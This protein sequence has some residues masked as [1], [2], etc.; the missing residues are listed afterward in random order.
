MPFRVTR[1][2]RISGASRTPLTRLSEEEEICRTTVRDFAEE[3]VRPR[4]AE[5]ERD[6]AQPRVL[7]FQK[8]HEQNAEPF[9]WKFTRDDL[10]DLMKKLHKAQQLQEQMAA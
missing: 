4:V 6:A 10:A 7:G 8:R 3:R 1:S 9:E 5:M 2:T